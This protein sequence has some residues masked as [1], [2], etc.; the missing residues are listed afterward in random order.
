MGRRQGKAIACFLV[1]ALL[2]TFFSGCHRATGQGV[3]IRI[4]YITDVTGPGSPVLIHFTY[5]LED[6]VRY[7]NEEN[8]I[9]GAKI[10]IV[11]YDTK[12]DAGRDIPGYDWVRDRG[13]QV[14]IVCLAV[15]A[16]TVKSFAERDKIPVAVM[17]STKALIEP[18]G[19]AFCFSYPASYA[20]E[21]LLKWISEERW[22]WETKGP[23]KIGCVSW[24]ESYS[25]D[26]EEGM[27]EY[28]QAHPDKFDYVAGLL[29]PRGTMTWVG[30]VEKL[31]RC[32]YVAVPNIPIAAGTFVREFRAG[33]NNAVFIG[34]DAVTA[35]RDYLV[36]MC[37]WEAIDGMLTT[38]FTRTW[39]E[40]SPLVDLAKDLLYEYHPERAEDIISAGMGYLGGFH[41]LYTFFDLLRKVVEEVGAENFDSQAFYDQA[42]KFTTNWEGYPEW[43]FTE[44]VRYSVKHTAIYEARADVDDMVR[45]SDWLPVT[46][47]A[48]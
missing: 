8:L 25:V 15:T 36:K 20:V 19:W 9:P 1:L 47:V 12:A 29:P 35:S 28:C 38:N 37:G 43:G 32:D 6:L 7:Y 34:P 14:L 24:S 31:K 5:I 27:Q 17:P 2:A 40:P 11:T 23:A 10:K 46:G 39:S 13:A 4:G 3:T 48:E 21:S 44:T 26:V 16:E 45:V 42:V 33:G 30:E 41:S 18:P 22:D